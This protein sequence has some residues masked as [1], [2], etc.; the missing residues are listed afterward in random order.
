LNNITPTSA[1]VK[2][3][4]ITF[5]EYHI[6]NTLETTWTYIAAVDRQEQYKNKRK[7]EGNRWDTKPNQL[8]PAQE[9]ITKKQKPI[10]VCMS[11]PVVE[12]CVSFSTKNIF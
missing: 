5:T 7:R 9:S 11:S 3:G 2:L 6:S 10:S 12:P 4:R 8:S 1:L